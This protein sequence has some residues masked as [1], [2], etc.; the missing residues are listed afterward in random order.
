MIA[1]LCATPFE[2]KSIL[3]VLA[4]TSDSHAPGGMRLV[5]GKVGER[6]VLALSTGVGK[7]AAGAG[8][9]FLLDRYRVEFILIYGIAGALSPDVRLGDLVLADEL[10]YGDVGVAHSGGFEITGPGLCEDGRLVFHPSFPATPDM[11]ER[12]RAAAESSGLPYHVGKVITCDQVVLDPELRV[13]LGGT[14]QAL[15]V[16]MEGAAAAQV[17][18]CDEVPF[19]AVRAISDELS[20]DFVGLEKLLEYKGQTRRSVWNK[21]A[22]LT[23]TD[24]GTIARAKE[25]S[26]GSKTALASLTSYLSTFL[27]EAWQVPP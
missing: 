5:T 9:R 24:P 27:R 19:I 6:D 13:H 25:M 17:A 16:E 2:L 22:R 4:R 10:V 20:H 14:F 18:A 11:L 7:V 12:A 8:T 26:R 15:A 21:R 3:S 1:L 23:V